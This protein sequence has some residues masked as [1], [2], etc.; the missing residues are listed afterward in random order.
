MLISLMLLT[1]YRDAQ[2]RAETRAAAYSQV[3]AA[4]IQ[5]LMEASYQALSRIDV[6]VGDSLA[7]PPPSAVE[8]LNAA[9][10]S[11]PVAVQGWVFDVAGNPRLTNARSTQRVNVSDRE[12]FTATRDGANFFI[13]SLLISRSTG[14]AVFTVAKRITRKGQFVGTAIVVIPA[15]Y[16]ETFRK[17]LE[18]G[19]ASTV[20]LLRADGMMVSRSPVPAEATDLSQ[21][22][23]FTDYLTKSDEG[24]YFSESPTD[25]IK[26]IVG[27]RRVPGF[28]LVAVASIAMDEAFNTFWQTVGMIAALTA[29]GVL[30]FSYFGLRT[31]QAQANLK[32]ALERNQTLFREIHHRVKNNLQQVLA[33]VQL[34]PLDAQTKDEMARRIGAMVS[35]HEHM[36]RSDVYDNVHADAYIPPLIEGIRAS[37]AK[38]INMAVSIAPA[39]LDRDHALPLAL[40]CNEVIGNAIKHAFPEGRPGKIFIELAEIGPQRARL[41]IKD[42]GVGFDPT[43]R[44]TGMGNRLVR[45]LAAQLDA[46]HTIDFDSGTVFTLEFAVLSFR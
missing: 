29:P 28:P 44:S 11:L 35:V 6:A 36:Y 10:E 18:L 1:V 32:A 17:S 46:Q 37:F 39:V 38:P 15:T 42:D 5:W 7:S 40:I 24:V 41:I 23:L 34:Q 45:S 2:G 26:R 43:Q 20:G 14:Q 25:G 19:P 33:L 8:D 31:S 3:V 30:G 27:Y 4:N 16:L 12:Y 9:V 13:S 22:V 21:Y